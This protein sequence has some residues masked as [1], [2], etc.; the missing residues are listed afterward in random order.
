[1]I[2]TYIEV[3]FASSSQSLWRLRH[4]FAEWNFFKMGYSWSLFLDNAS[5]PTT[6]D[7]E[8]PNSSL[9]K[10]HGIIRYERKVFNN[11][12]AGIS[13]ESPETG[14][15]N[16]ADTL[17]SNKNKQGNF[18]IAGRYKYNI[19][20]SHVQVAGIF[21]RI[22][23][24]RQTEMDVMYGWGFLFSTGINITPK[25]TIFAQWSFGDGIANYYT[26]FGGR[27]LDA[28]YDPLA[29][30]MRLKSIRGGFITYSY[31]F[32]PSWRFSITGGS[33]YIKGFDFESDDTFM[34]S[35]YFASSIFYNPIETI[36]LGVQS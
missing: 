16:P 8:G 12:T 10:R 27:Q 14:Y 5:T 20:P 26:G 15:Y 32:N 9:S 17:I 30:T 34:S 6:I 22:G 19:G 13:V 3:D 25:A 1:M 18:D 7:F 36:R 4:A 24:L 28:V 33:S 31:I 35:K 21:R 23:Y 2:R 29:E 11:S